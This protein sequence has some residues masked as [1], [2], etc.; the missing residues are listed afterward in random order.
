MPRIA[1]EG[2]PGPE[3]TVPRNHPVV[4]S[5]A[6]KTGA[7]VRAA[8]K[9]SNRLLENQEIAAPARGDDSP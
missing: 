8:A 6:F 5:D 1:R 3:V 9:Q 4:E 2:R 7:G